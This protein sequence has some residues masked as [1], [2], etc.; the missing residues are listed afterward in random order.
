M[1]GPTQL[2]SD[3]PACRVESAQVELIDPGQ[4]LGVSIEGLCRLCG[5][6]TELG[7]VVTAGEQFGGTADVLAGLTRWATEEGEADL[8]RFAAANF[9]GRTPEAVATAVL[10]GERVDTGFDVIAYLFPN[11]SATGRTSDPHAPTAPKHE[12]LERGPASPSSLPP[13]PSDPRDVGRALVS[14]MMAD[15]KIRKEEEAF[16]AAAMRRLEIPPLD[17]T[18]LRVWRPT[19]IGPVPDPAG[20]IQAMRGLALCDGEV[21]G[22]ELR[23]IQEFARAWGVPLPADPL[24]TP[25]PLA[26]LGR[27]LT[28][29]LVR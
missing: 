24:P 14:V 1:R 20:L 6:G 15:G 12:P 3:C 16:L 4:R 11:L 18:D 29:L 17:P 5:Y 26:E 21:D 9:N 2:L 28:R 10:A 25:G 19:E 27:A 23:V 22:S 13:R 7:E 8:V